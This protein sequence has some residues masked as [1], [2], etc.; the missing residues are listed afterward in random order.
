MS[1]GDPR[2]TG[3]MNVYPI[4]FTGD[5]S[6][7]HG[8]HRICLVYATREDADTDAFNDRV[9]CI[10]VDIPMEDKDETAPPPTEKI[11]IPCLYCGKAL[12]YPADSL[13]AQGVFNAFCHDKDCEDL[14]AATL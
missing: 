11:T 3:W 6:R 13:E 8:D 4:L 1:A 12:E 14:F 10:F 2:L 5:P 7:P 9:A